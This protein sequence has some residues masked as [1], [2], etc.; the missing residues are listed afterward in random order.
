M[1]ASVHDHA[2]GAGEVLAAVA[3]GANLGDR[4]ATLDA[5]RDALAALDGVRLLAAS[6]WIETDPVGPPG[7]GPYLN[8]AAL[9]ATVL[10]PRGLLE[11][12]LAIERDFGR[13]RAADEVRWGPRTLDLDLLL[14]GDAVVAE[15]GLHLPHPRLHE[16]RFVLEPLAEVGPDLVHPGRGR[17]VA[18]LLADLVATSP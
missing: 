5:A 6:A 13:I 18:G 15:E 2:L 16:R 11:A 3:F 7:Q 12:L 8:G 17:S 9:V 4:R 14:H 1:T 10:P